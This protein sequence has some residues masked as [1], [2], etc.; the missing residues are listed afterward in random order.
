MGNESTASTVGGGVLRSAPG[1]HDW[2]A[3]TLF[4]DF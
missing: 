2:V 4:E 1:D 3:G